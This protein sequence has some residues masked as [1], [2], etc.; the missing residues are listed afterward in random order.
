MRL[1]SGL[2]NPDLCHELDS[3]PLGT[4]EVGEGWTEERRD[5]LGAVG[6]WSKMSRLIIDSNCVIVHNVILYGRCYIVLQISCKAEVLSNDLPMD[7]SGE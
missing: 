4:V 7:G 5:A 1:L 3:D 2:G 6:R